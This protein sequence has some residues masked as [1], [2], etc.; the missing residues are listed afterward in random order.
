VKVTFKTNYVR[1]ARQASE[2]AARA[3][4]QILN[5]RFQAAL[6]APVFEWTPG[7]TT[8][9]SK[10]QVGSPRNVV[11][12]GNL[13]NSNTGPVISGLRVQF[14]WR[15]PYAAAVHEGAALSNGTILPAR[16]WTGAVLGTEPVNGIPVLDYRTLFRDTW[17]KV[18]RRG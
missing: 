18:F 1:N 11:D 5:A 9:R 7:V 10:G 2:Q 15:T 4:F 3:S 8:V 12:T 6:A 17:L 13:R 16:P 14:R